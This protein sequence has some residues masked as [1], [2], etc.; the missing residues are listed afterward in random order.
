MQSGGGGGLSVGANR[1]PD[2]AIQHF[3]GAE[4]SKPLSTH[5]LTGLCLH[6]AGRQIPRSISCS[7]LLGQYSALHQPRLPPQNLECC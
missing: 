5:C 1:N 2:L 7:S 6:A 4:A 3:P